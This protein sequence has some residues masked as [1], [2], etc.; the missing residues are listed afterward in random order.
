MPQPACPLVW[1]IIEELFKQN[2]QAQ[3]TL[4]EVY[5]AIHPPFEHGELSLDDV[6]NNLAHLFQADVLGVKLGDGT[7]PKHFLRVQEQQPASPIEPA[8]VTPALTFKEH[9]THQNP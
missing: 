7:P 9:P 8:P 1:G 6:S 5:A 4:M 2:P 3:L